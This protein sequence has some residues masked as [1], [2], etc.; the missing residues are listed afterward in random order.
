M[1]YTMNRDDAYGFASFKRT[2]TREIG[3]ELQFRSCPVCGGGQHSD[4]YTFSINLKSGACRCLRSSC[5]Y[6][7]HFVVL[8]RDQGYHLDFGES[9]TYRQLPQPTERIIPRDEAVEYL[10]SR[11]ISKEITQRY[12][13]TAHKYY[14]TTLVF[15]F[16]DEC[17]VLRFIKYRD[18]AFT[19]DSKGSKEWPEK[20][21]MPILFGIKQCKD[22]SRLII[23]EGQIDALSVAESGIDNAVSVP[24]GANGFQWVA[25]CR[26]WVEQFGEIIVFGDN[27]H[28][29]ITLVDGIKNNFPKKL[30]K[31]VR[32]VDYLGE[33]DAND[34]LRSFGADAVRKC[35]ENAEIPQNK[36]IVR[37][38]D[39]QPVDLYSLEKIQTGIPTLDR[40]IGGLV[41]GQ[42]IILTGKRG[43]GKS[44]FMSQLI[45]SCLQDTNVFAY[46]GELANITFKHG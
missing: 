6:K 17:G 11:C 15:P 24:M 45:C 23:T 12:E 2:E 40:Y 30:I 39:I 8:C 5:D 25:N 16:Y 44:T 13:V 42:L 28:G 41:F 14:P 9:R 19:K 32:A 26:E 31:V 3:D 21:T 7:G 43:E 38:A 46:S 10:Q 34:I 36:R 29:K 27:E 18:T 33:K 37:L 1:R 22:F 20:D 35:V 4:K